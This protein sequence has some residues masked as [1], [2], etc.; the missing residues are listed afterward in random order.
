M[1]FPLQIAPLVR[2]KVEGAFTGEAGEPIPFEFHLTCERLGSQAAIDALNTA[3]AERVTANST[4]PLTDALAPKVRGWQLQDEAGKEV[5]FT[6]DALLDVLNRPGVSQLA[7]ALL[8]R[9]SGAK[10]K[11]S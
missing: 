3:I 6:Q 1:S 8:C 7:Y 10:A 11:N 4:T 9:E 2:F 5:P